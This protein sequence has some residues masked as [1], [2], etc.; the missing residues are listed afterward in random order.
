MWVVSSS[1]KNIDPE[2][3]RPLKKFPENDVYCHVLRDGPALGETSFVGSVYKQM[4]NYAGKTLYIMT[5]YLRK[6]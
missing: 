2:I 1:E 6:Q 3:Y 5:P 4:I